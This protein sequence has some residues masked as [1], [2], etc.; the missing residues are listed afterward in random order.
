MPLACIFSLP[1]A[2]PLVLVLLALL[3]AFLLDAKKYAMETFRVLRH[4]AHHHTT[5]SASPTADILVD[6]FSGSWA[7]KFPRHSPSSTCS[8][9]S[10]W[11]GA[12]KPSCWWWADAKLESCKPLRQRETEEMVIQT[13]A[14]NKSNHLVKDEPP[15]VPPL[16]A[17]PWKAEPLVEIPVWPTEKIA[18]PKLSTAPPPPTR[19]PPP[20]PPSPPVPSSIVSPLALIPRLPVPVEKL[21]SFYEEAGNEV[22]DT[23]RRRV[24]PKK[25]RDEGEMGLSE[26][27][28][29]VERKK[30]AEPKRRKSG[31]GVG[32]TGRE[33]G[34]NGGRNGSG[35][36]TEEGVVKRLEVTSF[37][38]DYGE[39]INGIEVRF[40]FLFNER[41]IR[42]FGKV[43]SLRHLPRYVWWDAR[44]IESK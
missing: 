39:D 6:P 8:S 1:S 15:P 28:V 34:M 33:M 24:T 2:L 10:S 38:A 40:E 27:E 26:E 25:W 12:T 31:E 22:E 30:L 35:G 11:K 44:F 37:G 5:P 3:I 7:S 16:P 9:L 4:P 20:P 29:P 43:A 41:Q 14:I 18:P 36:K 42:I 21:I 17:V 19:P 23:L 13:S 32:E